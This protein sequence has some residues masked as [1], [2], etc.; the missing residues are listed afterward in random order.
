MPLSCTFRSIVERWARLPLY[1]TC[2]W[3]FSACSLFQQNQLE[4]V[5]KNG[6]LTVLTYL[7]ATT[8]YETPEGPAGFEYDLAKAF[9]D[10][11]GV[12]L[13]VVLAPRF[14]DLM[15]RVVRGEADF[16]AGLTVTDGRRA[17]LRFTSPYQE[18]RQQVVYRL[19]KIGRAHV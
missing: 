19:N 3:M 13:R 11:L 16:V 9:A 7:G 14:G 1:L 10:Y 2:L 12:E 17:Q 15:P 5:V 4:T 8:Y 18:I 6:E